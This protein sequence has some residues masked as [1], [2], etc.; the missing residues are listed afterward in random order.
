M[1]GAESSC[2]GVF[3]FISVFLVS[4]VTVVVCIHL[5]KSH[6]VRAH[7][8]YDTRTHRGGQHEE[9]ASDEEPA[10]R[11][12]HIQVAGAG[13]QGDEAAAQG[14]EAAAQNGGATAQGGG[15]A[16]QGGGA[17]HIRADVNTTPTGLTFERWLVRRSLGVV[18][19]SG[20]NRFRTPRH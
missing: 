16:A 9:N 1:D 4:A 12:Q 3:Y 17:C 5:M 8:H 2:T 20:N 11:E 13:A 15:A 18:Y 10:F 6:V 7:T 14:G 19:P